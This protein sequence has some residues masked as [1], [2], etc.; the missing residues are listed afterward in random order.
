MNV[1]K[2][3]ALGDAVH[4]VRSLQPLNDEESQLT[5]VTLFSPATSVLNMSMTEFMFCSVCS[6]LKHTCIMSRSSK[7]Q[8]FALRAFSGPASWLLEGRVTTRLISTALTLVA[9]VGST[10]QPPFCWQQSAMAATGGQE[11]GACKCAAA[12]GSLVQP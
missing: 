12:E 2:Q 10:V 7:A 9:Q 5:T 8:T 4:R 6:M 1:H 3:H 11:S